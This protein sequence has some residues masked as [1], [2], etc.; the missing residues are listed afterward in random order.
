MFAG[1]LPVVAHAGPPL[2]QTIAPCA[3]GLPGLHDAPGVQG[4][5]VPEPLQTPPGQALPGGRFEVAAQVGAPVA[6]R[7]DPA[8]QGFPGLQA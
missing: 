8:T 6:Q 4:T 1:A 2:A 7:V 5:Q 3:Q